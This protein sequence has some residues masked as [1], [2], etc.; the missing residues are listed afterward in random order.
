MPCPPSSYGGGG[1]VS[2]PWHN[3]LGNIAYTVPSYFEPN[4]RADLVWILHRAE[5]E[6]KKVKAVGSGWSFEDCAVSEDWV[7]DLKKLNKTVTFL[8]DQASGRRF[9]TRRVGGPTVRNIRRKALLRGSRHQD[10]RPEPA[11]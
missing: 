8:T 5:A 4:S 11:T 6:G 1:P 7:V 2:R 10:L 3:W 9:L